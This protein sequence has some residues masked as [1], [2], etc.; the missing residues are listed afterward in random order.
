MINTSLSTEDAFLKNIWTPSIYITLAWKQHRLCFY[1]C[2]YRIETLRHFIKTN[3]YTVFF[4][5]RSHFVS[6]F[7]YPEYPCFDNGFFHI[8]RRTSP[9]YKTRGVNV[10]SL[11]TVVVKH[12]F[13]CYYKLGIYSIVI[14]N[15]NKEMTIKQW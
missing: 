3:P 11:F 12:S 9:L 5:F 6:V 14:T 8:Q 13:S 15:M 1:P 4:Y 10:R 7:L 2:K